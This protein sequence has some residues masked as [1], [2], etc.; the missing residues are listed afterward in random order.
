[1]KILILT[2]MKAGQ[3]VL[4]EMAEIAPEAVIVHADD[5]KTAAEHIRE[6]EIII[7]TRDSFP[8]EAAEQA[9]ALKWVHSLMVGVESFLYPI[10]SDRRIILTNPRGAADVGVSEHVFAMILAWTRGIQES[11]LLQDQRVWERVRVTHL[12][13]KTMGIV[14]LGSIG[15]EVARKAKE[16]FGMKVIAT[17]RRPTDEDFVDMILPAD[18]L[19]EVLAAADFVVVAAAM[20]EETKGLINEDAFRAMKPEAFLVNIARGAIVDEKALE[21]ALQNGWI[22]GAGLDVFETEPLPEDSP[23]WSM[24]GVIVSPHIAGLSGISLADLRIGVFNDNLKAYL[25]GDTLPT[26]VDKKVGY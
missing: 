12:R 15:K 4:K 1:M 25:R 17:K 11:V 3:R 21:N 20:T 22:A 8:P 5:W 9:H 7:T 18:R 19:N 6:A 26:E 13:G 2:K 24:P 14:G 23:L 10:F 16:A